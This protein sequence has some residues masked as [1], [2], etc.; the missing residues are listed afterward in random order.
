MIALERTQVRKLKQ[1]LRLLIC[2][3]IYD[4]VVRSIVNQ[5]SMQ[6]M[7]DMRKMNF[8]H[9]LATISGIPHVI[10]LDRL[11]QN[12]Y[13]KTGQ[14]SGFIGDILTLLEKYGIMSYIRT[15][16]QGGV[17]PAKSSWKAI[18]KEQIL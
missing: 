2:M 13:K 1:M 17:F 7:V 16:I 8:L 9:K 3:R 6:S 14:L 12:I 11:Y 18:V 15:Y 5:L 4:Y 10:F